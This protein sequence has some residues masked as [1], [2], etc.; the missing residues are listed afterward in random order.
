MSEVADI[1]VRVQPRARRNE[2]VGEREG[3]L[4]VRVSA[5]P[6][7]G[8]ANEAVRKL[9]A[10]SLGIAPGR[11]TIVRGAGARDKSVRVEGFSQVELRTAL[12]DSASGR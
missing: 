11:V 7:G 4:L 10:R 5:A 3:V 1:R 2:I 6:V 9:I 8:K 12:R